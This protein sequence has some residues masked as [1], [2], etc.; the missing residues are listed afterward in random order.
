MSQLNENCSLP[1]YAIVG[2][3]FSLMTVYISSKDKKRIRFHVDIEG[4]DIA[5]FTKKELLDF[6]DYLNKLA[7]LLCD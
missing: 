7:N 5:C 6:G 4:V 1:D 2:G 3:E